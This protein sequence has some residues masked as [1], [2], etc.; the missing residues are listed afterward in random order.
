MVN[1]PG[2][3]YRIELRMPFKEFELR[4]QKKRLHFCI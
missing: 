1:Q 4:F 2:L 3:S